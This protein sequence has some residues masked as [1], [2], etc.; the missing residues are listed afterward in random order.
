MIRRPFV[1]EG[2]V[3]KVPVVHASPVPRVRGV[4][5]KNLKQG[6]IEASPLR[7]GTMI[8]VTAEHDAPSCVL[9]HQEGPSLQ[10]SF[11]RY[12]TT[13]RASTR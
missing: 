10:V 1:M 13:N 5:A 2:L 7:S 9:L 6:T 12:C 3:V 8:E 11:N 4:R